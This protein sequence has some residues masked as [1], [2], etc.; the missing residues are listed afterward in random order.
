MAKKISLESKYSRAG[1][2]FVMPAAVLIFV[3]NFF[4][5][6]RAFILSL[7]SGVANNLHFTG[8]RNYLRLLEDERFLYSVRNVF[9]YLIFQVP[10]MLFLAIILAS[11]LND[12]RLKFKGL[13]RTIVFLPCAT[14]LVS[15]ALIFKSIFG[16]DGIMNHWLLLLGILDAPKNWLVEIGRAHV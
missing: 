16:M 4:P 11:I 15:S 2:C 6:V 12:N 3:L 7:Q 10:L 8:L 9:I 5:M 14:A 13:F 1:W